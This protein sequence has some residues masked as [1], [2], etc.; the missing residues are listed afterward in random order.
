MCEVVKWLVSE[1]HNRRRS[2]GGASGFMTEQSVWWK[3][4]A[5]SQGQIKRLYYKEGDIAKWQ[6]HRCLSCHEKEG[7]EART[8]APST[9]TDDSTS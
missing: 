4:S 8:T 6:A 9:N 2:R 3:Y 5:R 7:G 1:A